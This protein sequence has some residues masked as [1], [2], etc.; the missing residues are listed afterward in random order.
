MPTVNRT[1]KSVE[2]VPERDGLMSSAVDRTVRSNV[3][4]HDPGS[5]LV[6]HAA[7]AQANVWS[8]PGPASPDDARAR[9][10]PEA[11]PAA[12][13]RGTS[14]RW[15]SPSGPEGAPAARLAWAKAAF[16]GPSQP[17]RRALARAARTAPPPDGRA[18][19][20][21]RGNPSVTGLELRQ[22]AESRLASPTEPSRRSL[23]AV[24]GGTLAGKAKSK[25]AS[26]AKSAADSVAANGQVSEIGAADRDLDDF[27]R[28]SSKAASAAS[29]MAGGA[30]TAG[31]AASRARAWASRPARSERA[32]AKSARAYASGRYRK[33]A[34]MLS[35]SKRLSQTRRASAAAK[36]RS[37]TAALARVAKSKAAACL[38][39]GA[40]AALA[41]ILAVV[42][43][44][45]AVGAATAGRQGSS[46][47]DGN[48]GVIA[49]YLMGHGVDALHVAAIL[50][51][52]DQE[53]S[54][55][56]P[57]YLETASDA[58]GI[59]I[60]QWPTNSRYG[61]NPAGLRLLAYANESGR[62]WNDINTQLDFLWFE[63]SGE[64]APGAEGIGRYASM[65][66]QW[67]GE[68]SARNAWF[69]KWGKRDRASRAGFEAEQDL[70]LATEYFTWGYLRPA[71]WAAHVDQR[72]NGGNG[73]KGAMY[74][75]LALMGQGE[76][77]GD[78]VARAYGE[79]GKPYVWGACG[80]SSFDCSG[81]VGYCLT[82]RY[83]HRIGTTET[84]M[85]WPRVDVPQ[86]GDVCTN[87]HHCGIYIGNG[88]MIHAPHTGD[89][90]KI[91]PVQ[92]SMIYV[93]YPG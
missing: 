70:A 32:A 89:F 73:K 62:A 40:G 58:G 15:E 21:K 49:A 78:A 50:G 74:Y 46:Q 12:G 10:V 53:T 36:A 44:V 59:G 19:G 4:E 7:L 27:D 69:A 84:F 79:I 81:L 3:V 37:A 11:L 1:P 13:P 43:L 60:C 38:A 72:I 64:E 93:R 39:A 87:S 65:Q 71:G 22:N 2:T 29:R 6:D 23:A 33:S 42:V 5:L 66:W 8:A 25:G 54:G 55:F 63:Y 82:G 88:Q 28:A 92:P 77:N 83:G 67:T 31:T 30:R 75:Y 76:A 34:R 56:D 45:S 18:F 47:L 91:G 20:F 90:V 41:C 61:S 80:P 86:P 16:A 14:E 48:A 85:T 52:L 51:N 24:A 68:T 57:S 17:S 9:L 35:K 26:S